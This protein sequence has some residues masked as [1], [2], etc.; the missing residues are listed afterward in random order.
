MVACMQASMSSGK[1]EGKYA[2]ARG[3]Q[4]SKH[5][6]KHARQSDE[7]GVVQ[8]RPCADKRAI[9]GSVRQTTHE[10]TE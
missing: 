8:A 1:H 3:E 7:Q 5:A 6:G 2:S 9:A 4:E 10:F